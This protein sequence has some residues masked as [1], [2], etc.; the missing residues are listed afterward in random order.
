MSEKTCSRRRAMAASLTMFGLAVCTEM[1]TSLAVAEPQTQKKP[2]PLAG[3]RVLV[4]VSDFSE[5]LETYYMVFRLIEEGAVPVVAA[6][7]IKRLQT[8][9]H[10]SDPTL[11][12]YT[13]KPAY[14]IDA[15]IAFKDIKPEE[16]DG[17]LLPGG[18]APED[19]R[20]DRHLQKTV[21]YL[22]DNN[23]PVGAMCHGVQVLTSEYP[24][25]GRTMTGTDGIF[26]DMKNVGINVVDEPVVVDGNLVTSRGWPD[27]PYFMP[28][29]LAALAC[30]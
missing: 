23:K 22:L 4:C 9:C 7:V 16:Y 19:I 18:R 20:Q 17:L 24:L 11:L 14:G 30:E 15:K 28:E 13:E 6:P 25:R 26:A 10:N 5:G 3:K 2:K 27:L 12:S 21:K 29:F 8:V 1:R